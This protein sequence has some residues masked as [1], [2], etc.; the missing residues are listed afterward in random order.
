MK[1]RSIYL[2]MTLLCGLLLNTGIFAQNVAI[3]SDGSDPDPSAMLDIQSENMGLL[4]PRITE[5][6]RPAD[7]ATGLLIYQ[8]DG[9]NGFYYYDGR[10]WKMISN[11][12]QL[13]TMAEQNADNVLITGGSIDGVAI[14]AV[15][16]STGKFTTLE[17]SATTTLGGNLYVSQNTDVGYNFA[18]NAAT[19]EVTAMGVI[20][21]EEFQ[22]KSGNL[23]LAEGSEDNIPWINA[24]KNGNKVFEMG[25][26]TDAQGNEAGYGINVN[27]DEGMPVTGM[28]LMYG[29]WVNGL[30]DPFTGIRAGVGADGQGNVWMEIV[31]PDVKASIFKADQNGDVSLSNDLNVGN[32]AQINSTLTV[33]QLPNKS[34]MTG[35]NINGYLNVSSIA[36]FY[37]DVYI[38][39]M[40][41]SKSTGGNLF[42]QNDISAEGVIK[43]D[44]LQTYSGNLRIAEDDNNLPW[45]NVLKNGNKVFEMGLGTDAQGADAGYGLNINNDDGETV[46]GMGFSHGEWVNGVVDPSTLTIAGAT[47]DGAGSTM[48]QI[49]SMDV[50]GD[51]FKADNLGN[52]MMSNDLT[53]GNTAQVNTMLLVG[54]VTAKPAMNGAFIN[55]MLSVSQEASFY[56][57]VYVGAMSKNKAPGDGNLIV[58]NKLTAEDAEINGSVTATTLTM[59]QGATDGYFLQ[60][61][62]TGHAS[63]S[64]I[65]AE[66][67]GLGSMSLQNSN[68]VDITG[69]AINGTTIGGTAPAGGKFTTLDASG[70]TNIGGNFSV[71]QNVDAAAQFAV[72]AITGDVTSQ[73]ILKGKELQTLN[74]NFQ[75]GEG[76]TNN[77]P[78]IN[79]LK[80]GKKVFEMGLGKDDNGNDKS[81]ALKVNNDAGQNV[82]IIGYDQWSWFNGIEDPTTHSKFGFVTDGSGHIALSLM[83]GSADIGYY[84]NV[85]ENGNTMVQDLQTYGDATMYGNMTVGTSYQSSE[86]T[87]LGNLTVGADNPVKGAAS[88]TTINGPLRITSGATDGYVLTSDAQGNATWQEAPAG[89][90]GSTPVFGYVYELATIA[91]A[92]I[93]GGAD[94]VFSNRGPVNGITH[95]AGTISVAVTSAGVYEIDYSVNITAGV[96]SAIAI[97]INGTVDAS[98]PKSALV[99]TGE[100]SGKAMVALA[101]GDVITLRNDSATPFTLSLA[102]GVGAQLTITKV[103]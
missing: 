103:D 77:V 30:R 84:F 98:T 79:A 83:P 73:G 55:G 68:E 91:D 100:V 59:T 67:L 101:A 31:S 14:G 44:E 16:P 20:K 48:I 97:A 1:K 22:T 38:G 29:D 63:W 56:K 66:N 54:P 24:L 53:V 43:G 12:A 2:M 5:A 21:G 23:R 17:A 36:S 45:I 75:I 37:S 94:V 8:T 71:S 25:L 90:G 49:K 3:N 35:A 41:K 80:G 57:N 34:S 81:Y 40:T 102:P 74:G 51:L 64:A 15:D 47:T 62:A 4:I 19:G 52:V 27:N 33:G 11:N 61:D 82:A 96:G 42:V 69:G 13:G 76:V 70:T 39:A 9:D 50:K 85:D 93:A 6:N 46:A 18:V 87:V 10:Q 28:G 86:V 7:P 92:T 65:D 26:G 99:A 60:S 88:T 95:T 58:Q 89:G 78:Y 32:N 72:D